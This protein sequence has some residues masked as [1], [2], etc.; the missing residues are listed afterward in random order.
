[1]RRPALKLN[2][3]IVRGM[4]HPERVNEIASL[5]ETGNFTPLQLALM[6]DVSR[7]RIYAILR[8]KVPGFKKQKSARTDA[9]KKLY[10]TGKYNERE[11]AEM[12]GVSRQRVNQIIQI[13]RSSPG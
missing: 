2:Q 1:M 9:I 7:E 3:K 8:K 11:L 5:Y 13:L 4:R 12:F 6:F 10:K